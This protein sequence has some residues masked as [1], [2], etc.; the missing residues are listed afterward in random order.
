M[1]AII[2][3]FGNYAYRR[4]FNAT[5]LDFPGA[6]LLLS[7]GGFTMALACN[8]FIYTQRRKLTGEGRA[9]EGKEARNREPR[10]AEHFEMKVE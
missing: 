6:F 9:E 2:P 3:L 4:L 1:A 10:G 5:I 7:A 8:I